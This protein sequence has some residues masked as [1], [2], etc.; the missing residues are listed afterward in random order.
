[1]SGHDKDPSGSKYF[2]LNFSIAAEAKTVVPLGVPDINDKVENGLF[3]FNYIL[4]DAAVDS[5]M[6]EIIN[7]QGT[8]IYNRIHDS[9]YTLPGAHQISWDGFSN[10]DVYDSSMF[11]GRKLQAKITVLKAGIFE[12]LSINF[13]AKYDV[14]QWID[15]KIERR[16]KKITGTL[17][18]NFS[19]GGFPELLTIAIAGLKYH[20]G[21]N[22]CH[23]TGKNI[24]FGNDEAYEFF[25]N[26]LNTGSNAI[27]SPKIV[28]QTNARSRRSRNWE[29]SRILFYNT[30]HLQYRG[31]WYYKSPE[32]ADADFKLIA[33]HEIGHEILLAYGGHLYSK[34]HK[35]SSTLVTQQPLGNYTY[36]EYGEIDL[37]LYYEEDKLHPCPSDHVIRT[38][39]SEKDTLGLIWLSKLRIVGQI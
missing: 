1:M 20:W 4:S 7:D 11:I 8:L 3:I 17:R 33:A 2:L 21:R 31:K 36:P 12:T 27:K 18:T 25:L 14:V 35:G 37:M 10:D 5:V 34:T 38:V 29:L 9:I 39:A 30:G 19:D 22:D 24:V 28:Y 15:V 6:F 23:V 26:V 13:T 16:L 32:K